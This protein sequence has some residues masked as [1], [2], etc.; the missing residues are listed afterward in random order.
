MFSAI[1]QYLVQV[2]C[3]MYC[4]SQIQAASAQYRTMAEK[5]YAMI[6]WIALH[7]DQISLMFFTH[8]RSLVSECKNP[9]RKLSVMSNL[10]AGVCKKILCRIK[11][12]FFLTQHTMRLFLSKIHFNV[13]FTM[14]SQNFECCID[15]FKVKK[16]FIYIWSNNEFDI[17]NAIKGRP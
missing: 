7:S 16:C 17:K 12:F 3:T 11:Y 4:P 2:D 15:T 1:L 6:N 14:F 10:Q 9:R 5:Y 8:F 13:D